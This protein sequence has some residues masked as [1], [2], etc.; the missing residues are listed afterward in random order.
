MQLRKNRTYRRQVYKS[1][2]SFSVGPT[3]VRYLTLLLLAVFSLLYLV[4][5]AQG[6]NK[7][8]EIRNLDQKKNELDK[9]L[10]TLEVNASRWQSLNNLS[11][12][13]AKQQ[14][15]PIDGTVET[16]TLTP[17]PPAQQ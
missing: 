2:S 8:I 1:G 7:N 5:S 13:A 3:T 11:Q 4:Q 17:T 15:V 12:S 16:I 10:S 9:E 6:S 14:L